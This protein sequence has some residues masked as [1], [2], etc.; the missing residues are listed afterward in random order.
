[1]EAKSMGSRLLK[2]EDLHDHLDSKEL[3]LLLVVVV[4]GFA[5]VL[6]QENSMISRLRKENFHHLDSKELLLVVVEVVAVAV[7][8][9]VVDV[10]VDFAAALKSW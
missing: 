9:T 4:V 10:G 5:A 7:A 2:E 3:L 6:T 8:V 1:M